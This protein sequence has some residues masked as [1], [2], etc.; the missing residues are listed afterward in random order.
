MNDRLKTIVDLKRYPIQDLNSPNIKSLIQKCKEELDQFS[1]S[2]IPNFILP[3]SLEIMNEELKKKIDEV[4][5][6]NKRVN[7]YLYSKA[8]NTQIYLGEK[9][10]WRKVNETLCTFLT[11]KRVIEKHWDKLIN[12]C[13]F[14]HYPFEKPLHKIYNEELCISPIPSIATHFT[15]INSIFGLSPNI[16]WKKLWEET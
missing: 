4:Y 2:S 15:N 3:K 14:E 7:P 11:S 8:E 1:C 10:H 13:E 16:N 6:S 12:M 9:Y 5:M